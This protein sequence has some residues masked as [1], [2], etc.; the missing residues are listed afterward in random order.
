MTDLTTTLAA[1]SEAA[2][3]EAD[4]IRYYPGG[5]NYNASLTKFRDV[6][7]EAYRNGH[8]IV[9]PDREA[10]RERVALAI[11]QNALGSKQCPCVETGVFKCGHIYPGYQANAALTAIFGGGDE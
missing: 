11:C 2:D 4:D 10:L 1:L 6:L 7:T 3:E 9:K 8:L 5:S